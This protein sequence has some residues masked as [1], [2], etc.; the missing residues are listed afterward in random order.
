MTVN[1]LVKQM[2]LCGVMGSGRIGKA[3]SVLEKMVNEKDCVK[4]FGLAGAMVPGGMRQIIIDLIENNFFDVF[5]ATGATLTHDCVEALGIRHV[6]GSE[7]ESD[8]NYRQKGLDRMFDSLMPNSAYVELEKFVKDS[9]VE[10]EGEIAVSELLSHFGKCLK[11]KNSILSACYKKNIPIFCPAFT[12]SGLGIQSMFYLKKA[13]LDYFLDLKQIFDIAWEAKKKGIFYVGGG[14]PKNFVQQAL[15]FSPKPAD[16]A[17]QVTTDRPE[18]GGSSGAELRE[19]ISWGKLNPKANF[20]DVFCDATI[21]LPIIA[22]ALLE[23]VK[24]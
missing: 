7:R 10:L 17:V 3:V 12:D 20:V 18:F 23:R 21:A 24:K 16:F 4:F 2:E 8:E 14:V 9:C 5:V 15:Q 19:G 11:K 6:V 1:E 22:A 13:K